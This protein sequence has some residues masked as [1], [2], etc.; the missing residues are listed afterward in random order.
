MGV[1]NRRGVLVV[2]PVAGPGQIKGMGET[3]TTDHGPNGDTVFA[4]CVAETVRDVRIKIHAVS[5]PEN[6]AVEGDLDVKLAGKDVDVLPP[7]VTHQ[8]T[9]GAGL[10]PG[11]VCYPQK[12]DQRVCPFREPLPADASHVDLGTVPSPLDSREG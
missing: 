1:F 3:L 9:G 4:G 2:G 8:V 12:L 10:A 6:I 5:R 11:S 7:G